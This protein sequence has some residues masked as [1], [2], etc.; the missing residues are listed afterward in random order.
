[1]EVTNRS[2]IIINFKKPFVDWSNALT[3]EFQM[4]EKMLGE[5]TTYLVKGDLI[6]LKN[7]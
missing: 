7:L 5:S 3:P 4:S 1:M 6:M 2:T